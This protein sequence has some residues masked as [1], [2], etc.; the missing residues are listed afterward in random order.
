M[1]AQTQHKARL[2]VGHPNATQ[3]TSASWA[4]QCTSATQT[5]GLSARPQVGHPNATQGTSARWSAKRK[6]HPQRKRP[7]KGALGLKTSWRMDKNKFWL[8]GRLFNTASPRLGTPTKRKARPQDGCPNTTQGT[9]ASWVPQHNAR[10]VCKLGAPTDVR[11]A[12]AR[13]VRNARHVHTSA[14]WALQRNA[15]HVR[16]MVAQTQNSSATKT[17]TRRARGWI[18]TNFG[19]EVDFLIQ[20]HQGWA[21]QCNARHV[22]KLGAPTHVRNANARYVHTSA[23]WAPQRNARHVRK[24]VAQTQNSSATKTS[25]Q[26]S[27]R[28]KDELEDG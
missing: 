8:G 9:S 4:P 12:N 11:N 7:H 17:S 5:Q 13:Q 10:N 27:T 20:P 28:L 2:Q 24:M 18:R 6:P 22:R 21:P 25:T 1:G 15:R 14:S 16:K 23:S 26:G 19:L 3:G